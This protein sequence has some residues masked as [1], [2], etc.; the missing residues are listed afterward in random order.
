MNSVSVGRPARGSPALTDFQFEVRSSREGGTAVVEV[1]GEFDMATAPQV[2]A[3]IDGVRSGAQRVVVDLGAATF[4]DSAAINCLIHCQSELDR[5][6]G[7]VRRRE[8]AR[9]RRPQGPRDHEHGRAAR[10]RR[11]AARPRVLARPAALPLDRARVRGALR[12]MHAEGRRP[13]LGRRLDVSVPVI[14]TACADS[15][16]FVAW[17]HGKPEGPRSPGRSAASTSGTP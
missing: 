5:S 16:A 10:R 14:G 17:V 8:S 12:E 13:R 2:A 11:L 1:F 4:L 9:G 15:G 3:A 6:K 7:R